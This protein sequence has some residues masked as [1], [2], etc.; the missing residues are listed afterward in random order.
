[1]TLT[2][3]RAYGAARSQGCR[4]SRSW[5]SLAT[6][7]RCRT[8]VARSRWT[9]L[10]PYLRRGGLGPKLYPA[11]G[12]CA[13]AWRRPRPIRPERPRPRSKSRV[14][15]TASRLACRLGE[16]D[17]SVPAA[18]HHESASVGPRGDGEQ[19]AG[20][21]PREWRRSIA[22]SRRTRAPSSPHAM[23]APVESRATLCNVAV[24]L[25]RADR[26]RTAERRFDARAL[27]RER[28]RRPE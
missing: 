26:R 4:P 13:G 5:P 14:V 8:G 23:T 20:S 9:S 27:G 19:V 17:E 11:F 12:G 3:L 6:A 16:S 7:R 18:P 2:K 25:D 22:T 10:L 1:M 28:A 24:R 21:S 15:C